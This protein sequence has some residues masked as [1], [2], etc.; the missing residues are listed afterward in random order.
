MKGKIRIVFLAFCAFFVP[1]MAVASESL[2]EQIA[3]EENAFRRSIFDKQVKVSATKIVRGDLKKS[4]GGT[5]VIVGRESQN[6]KEIFYI[7]TAAHVLG[8]DEKTLKE[9]SLQVIFPTKES[10]ATGSSSHYPAE[11]LFFN[12]FLEYAF[13][14]VEVPLSDK[15]NLDVQVATIYQKIPEFLHEFWVSGFYKGKYLVANKSYL[16]RM[17]TNETGTYSNDVPYLIALNL[18]FIAS[19]VNGPGMSGGGIFNLKGE[20]VALIW[21]VEGQNIIVAIP[22][23]LIKE[24]FTKKLKSLDQKQEKQES[25]K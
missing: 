19:G 24:D 17:F 11:L 3:R 5:G 12:W 25:Q 10:F 6:D 9:A 21:A 7:I 23:L 22:A 8:E 16:S 20:L 14:K 15:D 18:Y 13:L 4:T 2:I 1:I